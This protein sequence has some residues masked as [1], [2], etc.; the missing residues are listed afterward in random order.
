[1]LINASERDIEALRVMLSP[2]DVA[3]EVFGFH[4]QQAA[5]KALKSW[6]A[7]LGKVFPLTH[8]LQSLLDLLDENNVDTTCYRA[9]T[10]YTPYAVRFRYE[11]LEPSDPPL[12]RENALLLVER[13]WVEV[14]RRLEDPGA[15]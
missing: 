13:L 5:E 12:D 15:S 6:L 10:E 7:P 14:R 4:V 1:M 9:L 11:F 2:E 3:D 8:N